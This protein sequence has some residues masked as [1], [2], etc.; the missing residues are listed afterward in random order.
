MNLAISLT[1]PDPLALA[2]G[3][4]DVAQ[5]GGS[6]PVRLLVDEIPQPLTTDWLEHW[7]PHCEHS[8]GAFWS[9]DD[10][11]FYGRGMALKLQLTNKGDDVQEVRHLLEELPFD[12][13]VFR[14]IHP[15]WADPA[16]PY[17]APTFGEAHFAL[18]WGC[19]FKGVGHRQ[20]VSRRWLDF[21]P[22]RLVRGPG[23]LSLVQ[24]HD[25]NVDA[26]TAMD[27]ARPGHDRMGISP[28]GGYLQKNYVYANEIGGL[29]IPEERKLKIVVHGREIS[30]LEMRDAA[31]ARRY[32]DLGPENPVDGIAYVFME[33]APGRAYLRELWLRELE[34]WAL[35]DGQDSRL[36]L[37][38]QPLPAPPEWVGALESR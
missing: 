6:P 13:A 37:S 5:S 36:D 22:W 20:L 24:F 8:L 32:Q 25:L 27:Q 28:T 18:G 19:A 29:Y 3:L 34:V 4:V 23:D 9:D 38:Y 16:A 10:W 21:G 7:L 14:S 35:I 33:E 31:A 2:R 1:G 15:S 11:L 17:H 30:Q 12:V 26:A